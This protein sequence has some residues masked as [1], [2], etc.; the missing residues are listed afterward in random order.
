M[1]HHGPTGEG[2]SPAPAGRRSAE[3]RHRADDDDRRRAQLDAAQAGQRGAHHPLGRRRPAARSPPP[4]CRAPGRPAPARA[5]MAARVVIPMR[6][7]NVPPVPG[8]RLPVG[9]SPARPARPPCPV[10][11]VTDEARPRWVTGMPTAA[12]TPKA[13]VTPGTTSQAMPGRRQRLD[14][15]AAPAEEE[16]VAPLEADHHGGRAAR[17]R[18]AAG[19][20]PPGAPGPAADG[21]GLLA[22]VDQ[23]GRRAA[24]GRGRRGYQAVVEDDVGPGQQLGAAAGQEPGSPGPAPTR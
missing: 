19:R 24:P 10:T 4:A 15:L 22:D 1:T 14:L 8:Q 20:S 11:T 2:A 13:D 18:P 17:A 12:G 9:R 3:R 23:Q 21:V 16:R 6:I 7:T 5:A